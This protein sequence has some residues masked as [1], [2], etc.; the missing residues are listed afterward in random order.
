MLP[1]A[2]SLN[3]ENFVNMS[4]AH[5]FWKKEW[6]N[7][8]SVVRLMLKNL[9]RSSHQRYP[10]EKG[11]LRNFAKLTGKHMCQSLSFN[12]VVGKAF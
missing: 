2:I 3:K 1:T 12:K 7:I 10:K 11:T 5:N 4:H 9:S 8:G 6:I